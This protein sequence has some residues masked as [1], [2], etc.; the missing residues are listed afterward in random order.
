[1][2]TIHYP[3]YKR[4]VFNTALLECISKVHLLALDGNDEPEDRAL[5]EM[6]VRLSKTFFEDELNLKKS[7]IDATKRRLSESVQFVQ[8]CIAISEN[9]AE[10][11]AEVA[12]KE[13]VEFAADQEIELSDEDEEVI[14]QLFDTKSPKPQVD[15]IRDAT[16]KAL[17]EEDKKA[18]EVKEAIDIAHSKVAAGEDPKSLEETVTRINRQGPTSLMNAILNTVTST[19]IKDVSNAGNFTSVSKVM[20][21]NADQIKSRVAAIYALYET[22][23]VLGINKYTDR[24]IRNLTLNIFADK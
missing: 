22:A 3:E 23:S 6:A 20:Q 5:S 9:I 14:E 12:E 21:E 19:A 7:T 13:G 16:V 17:L 10:D 8:D 1:M 2:R 15:A 11:K 24:D 18:Q 4:R